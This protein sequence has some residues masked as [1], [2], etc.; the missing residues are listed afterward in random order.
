M[1]RSDM[2]FSETPQMYVS[3]EEL[4]EAELNRCGKREATIKTS[5]DYIRSSAERGANQIARRK[6]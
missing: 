2:W 3:L 6:L 5:Y 1:F 4:V